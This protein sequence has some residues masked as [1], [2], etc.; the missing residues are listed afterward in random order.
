MK[1][2]RLSLLESGQCEG[3]VWAYPVKNLKGVTEAIEFLREYHLRGSVPVGRK[4][5]V[6]GGGNAAVDA[7][8]T[9][10]RL[11]AKSVSIL[12]RRTRDEMPAY[13]EE[14]EEA[15]KEGV[16][17]KI[18]VAPVEIVRKN[19]HVKGVTCTPMA[20]GEFDQS[21]R[22]RPIASGKRDFVVEADQVITAIGQ[23]IDPQGIAGESSS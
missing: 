22:R 11:G 3:N 17:F 4:I 8:R 1:V 6:I 13:A 12:Y 16:A 14:I 15:E 18:L 23:A 21:G 10:V 20:L 7:A 9:A 5:V 19:G 2:M